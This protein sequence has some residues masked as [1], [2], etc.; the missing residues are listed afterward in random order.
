MKRA[1]ALPLAIAA[2]A[3]LGTAATFV[4]PAVPE[5]R[6]AVSEDGRL[7]VTVD[8]AVPFSIS[9]AGGMAY[10]VGDGGRPL[11]VPFALAYSYLAPD[12]ALAFYRF[13]ERT[14]SWRR[15][16]AADDPAAGILSAA[17]V[18]GTTDYLIA[19]VVPP[20]PHPNAPVVLDALL[21]VPPLG[22]V[23]YEASV[24]V[25][26]EV[27]GAPEFFEA[28]MPGLPGRGGC[29][30]AFAAGSGETA[31]TREIEAPWGLTRVL[32]RWQVDGGCAPGQ[33][34]S[35]AS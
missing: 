27:A 19:S 30:G 13:D 1:A 16:D 34:I 6:V 26:A 17:G 4:L 24:A 12:A 8:A 2:A 18:P 29:A 22:A 32:V 5:R 28:R 11:A 3:L 25:S 23:G 10:R 14:L 7:T 9:D 15:M 31:V 20:A 21:A 35:P 33:A